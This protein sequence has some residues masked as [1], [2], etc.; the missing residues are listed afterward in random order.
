M[1]LCQD[2]DQRSKKTTTVA[3]QNA[4]LTLTIL[5]KIYRI[6]TFLVVEFCNLWAAEQDCR[7]FQITCLF[8]DLLDELAT[9]K[10]F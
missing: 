3:A 4:L 9:F 7:E 10:L 5:Q 6:L 8:Y 2:F 1:T